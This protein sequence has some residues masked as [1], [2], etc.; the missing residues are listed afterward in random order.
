V[1]SPV[2]VQ[3]RKGKEKRRGMKGYGPEEKMGW[4]GPVRAGLLLE[5]RGRKGPWREREPTRGVLFFY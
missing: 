3:E 2:V 4:L 1:T 5:K